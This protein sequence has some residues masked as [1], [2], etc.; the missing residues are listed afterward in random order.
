VEGVRSEALPETG[1]HTFPTHIL[2]LALGSLAFLGGLGLAL[3]RR[4]PPRGQ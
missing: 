3:L 4:R 2:A 1:D